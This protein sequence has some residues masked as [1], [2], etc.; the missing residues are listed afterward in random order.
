MAAKSNSKDDKVAKRRIQHMGTKR[1]EAEKV[2]K[3]TEKI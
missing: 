3:E 1:K 2:K